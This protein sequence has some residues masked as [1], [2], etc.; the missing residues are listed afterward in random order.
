MLWF[1]VPMLELQIR[2]PLLLIPRNRNADR[3]ECPKPDLYPS[4][5]F[6]VKHIVVATKAVLVDYTM[7]ILLV[8]RR[9]DGCWALPYGLMLPGESAQECMERVVKSQTGVTVEKSA[10]FIADSGK[11]TRTPDNPVTQLVVFGFRVTK[12]SDCVEQ[13]NSEISASRWTTRKQACHLL[14]IDNDDLVT[15]EDHICT[16]YDPPVPAE[17][18]IVWVR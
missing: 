16:D 4:S 5:T 13:N 10:P 9:V 6:D 2:G 3:E 17:G 14:S 7:R 8:R 15:I 12:W 1:P 18:G 11:Y